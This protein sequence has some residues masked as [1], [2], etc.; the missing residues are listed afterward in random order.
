[1]SIQYALQGR[2]DYTRRATA[3]ALLFSLAQ[4][5]QKAE[6]R[7]EIL[8]FAIINFSPCIEDGDYVGRVF[9]QE[10]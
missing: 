10:G 2:M 5:V 6:K 8:D 7:G 9:M 4:Q 1:M 3:S